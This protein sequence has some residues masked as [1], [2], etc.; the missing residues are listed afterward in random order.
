MNRLMKRL[1]GIPEP[2]VSVGLNYIQEYLRV[3]RDMHPAHDVMFRGCYITELTKEELET[4][5][6]MYMNE[7]KWF[8]KI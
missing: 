3:A 2:R 4:I 5:I 1:L 6:A 8:M 7:S